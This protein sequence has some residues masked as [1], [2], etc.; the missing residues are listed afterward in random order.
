MFKSSRGEGR[1]GR[2]RR[3]RTVTEGRPERMASAAARDRSGI[4]FARW[5]LLQKICSKGAVKFVC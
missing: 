5:R 1:C 2:G 4:I 3:R